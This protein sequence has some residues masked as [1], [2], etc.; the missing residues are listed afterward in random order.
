MYLNAELIINNQVIDSQECKFGFREVWCE[1]INFYINGMRVNLRGD[2]WHYQGFV[3]QTKE[4]ALNWY[5]LCKDAGMNF[6]RL[7]AMPYPEI[8]LDAADEVGMLIIDES[9]I[10]GSSKLLQSDHEEFIS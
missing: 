5:K 10:Y 3:Y 1:G 7:H 8:F 6:V 2:S 9:A 4:Y